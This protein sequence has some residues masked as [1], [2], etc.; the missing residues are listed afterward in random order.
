M[1]GAPFRPQNGRTMTVSLIKWG[2]TA[3]AGYVFLMAIA[4]GVHFIITPLYAGIVTDYP[5][6]N[7]FNW[8]LA[9]AYALALILNI[10]RKILLADSEEYATDLRLWLELNIKFWGAILLFI[11]FYWN[12][13]GSWNWVG[14][15]GYGGDLQM[16]SFITPPF[17]LLGRSTGLQS[18]REGSRT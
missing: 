7:V 18:W 12:W 10:Y 9:V 8:F 11:L 3:V 13:F 1:T 5:I 14:A 15:E 6:W 17:V 16:W 2:R 4:V